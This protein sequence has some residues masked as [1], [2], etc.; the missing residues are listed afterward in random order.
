M[1]LASNWGFVNTGAQGSGGALTFGLTSPTSLTFTTVTGYLAQWTTTTPVGF[2][3]L[4]GSGTLPTTSQAASSAMAV[5]NGKFTFTNGFGI[6]CNG[7]GASWFVRGG[8]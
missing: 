4:N 5:A 8:G 1:T 6:L 3:V 7:S 2:Q